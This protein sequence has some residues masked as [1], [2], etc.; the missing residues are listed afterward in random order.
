MV[1]I[2]DYNWKGGQLY[3][4]VNDANGMTDILSK[5]HDKSPNFHCRTLTSD[6][7][8]I[9][10]RSLRKEI[11]Q[12]FNKHADIMLFYFSGHG[13]ENSIGGMLVTQDAK[14]YDEGVAL[15]D[16]IGLANQCT[17]IKEIFIILDCCYSGH[18]GN[19]SVVNNNSILRKGVSVLTASLPNEV[20]MDT[21]GQG[22]FTK[23]LL[24][25]LSGEAADTIGL[26][27][28]ASLYNYADKILGYWEQRPIFKTH[29]T[30]MTPL[31]HTK[32]QVALSK[33][34]MITE[35][36]PAE[37]YH[38]PLDKSYEPTEDPRNGTNEAIFTDLQRFVSASLV[39]PDDEQHMYF[40]A[41]NEKSCSLTPLGKFYW[42]LVKSG[43]I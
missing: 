20:S 24:D 30:Q 31:R 2:N 35:Y 17:T 11:V 39:Q 5:N 23:I 9:T 21:G 22:L 19:N 36:F 10:R 32:P 16:I 13:S 27:T 34:Y 15:D 8:E 3:G 28:A 14:K 26:V 18:A 40:A 37:E 1:G 29:C 25:G 4:C 41:I 33:L 43:K 12:M 38:F 6:K 7:D 42:K